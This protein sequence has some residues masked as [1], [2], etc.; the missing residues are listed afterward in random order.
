[1]NFKNFLVSKDLH[2][3]I[4]GWMGYHILSP[5]LCIPCSKANKHFISKLSEMGLYGLDTAIELYNIINKGD[6]PIVRIYEV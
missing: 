2:A 1:M 6:L 5:L 3:D 4:G